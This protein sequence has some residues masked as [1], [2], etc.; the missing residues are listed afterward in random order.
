MRV[1]FLIT[2]SDQ[3]ERFEPVLRRTP[4]ARFLVAS[5]RWP[6]AHRDSRAE[7]IR[8]LSESGLAPVI[9]PRAEFDLVV[10]GTESPESSVRAWLRPR[11]MRVL[12]QEPD[13]PETSRSPSLILCA[14]EASLP[15][16]PASLAQSIGE[17]FLD[18]ALARGT[19]PQ[20]RHRLGLDCDA[21]RPVLLVHGEAQGG[22]LEYLAAALAALRLDF[23][24]LVSASELRRLERRVAIPS[25]LRGPGIHRLPAEF[26]RAEALAACD[27]VLAEPGVLLLQAAALGR[28]AVAL[29]A[30]DA[31]RGPRE[32]RLPTELVLDSTLWVHDPLELSGCAHWL[33][34]SPLDYLAELREKAEMVVGVIDGHATA[35]AVAALQI[36]A[37]GSQSPRSATPA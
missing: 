8:R 6:S 13:A 36:L 15:L 25:A 37:A 22:A 9:S 10:A 27:L 34:N 12:W 29:G 18:A 30:R 24:L 2:L 35:R 21:S 16:D 31:R 33:S 3:I 32:I 5:G 26:P 1:G 11:G 17:P 19:R 4:G 7:I 23:E 20:A 28:P 14:G